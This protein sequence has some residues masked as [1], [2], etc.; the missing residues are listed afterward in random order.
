MSVRQYSLYNTVPWIR[1][2][3]PIAFRVLAQLKTNVSR[4]SHNIVTLSSWTEGASLRG[5][6][7]IAFGTFLHDSYILRHPFS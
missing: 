1:G 7:P 3:G 4:F 2:G 5:E 6:G